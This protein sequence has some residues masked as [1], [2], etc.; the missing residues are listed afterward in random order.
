MKTTGERIKDIRLENGYT[1]KAFGIEIGKRLGS[2]RVKEGIISRWEN[3]ISLPNSE[4][5]KVVAELGGIP[6]KDLIS[7][8]SLGERI[9][10][11]RVSR[12]ETL[13]EFGNNISKIAEGNI[14]TSKSNVSKWEKG[15]NKPNDIA[16]K[17]I[18]KL[19]NTSV[20]K[21]L[22]S[23]PLSDYSTDELLQELERRGIS[24]ETTHQ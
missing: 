10:R 1:L 20:N 23:N 17:A 4:R 13:E 24:H 12:K 14:K 2:E 22:N 6:V 21:L 15:L 5:L 16:L 7:T 18:A 11:I 8:N 9:K 19:G 3:D